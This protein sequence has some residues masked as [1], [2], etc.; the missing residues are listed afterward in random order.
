MGELLYWSVVVFTIICFG[1][2]TD[3]VNKCNKCHVV[4]RMYIYIRN[5]S[6]HLNPL[7]RKVGQNL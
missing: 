1:V 2:V 7:F 3:F 6:L 5:K 4:L